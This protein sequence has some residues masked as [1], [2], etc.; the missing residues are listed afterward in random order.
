MVHGVPALT[1]NF[2][3]VVARQMNTGH[4]AH[5]CSTAYHEQSR[6]SKMKP[7][8]SSSHHRQPT[9]SK[10]KTKAAPPTSSAAATVT[11]KQK[12]TK[13]TGGA[14]TLKR[15]RQLRDALE[16]MDNGYYDDVFESTP[17]KKFKKSVMV[18][19]IYRSVSTINIDA[20]NF[21]RADS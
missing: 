13:V 9:G 8:S 7:S 19:N 2:W 3:E 15:K 18:K 4:T 16:E 17:F 21:E 10:E 11:A 20:L 5:Q 6:R 14:G 12:V 1:T